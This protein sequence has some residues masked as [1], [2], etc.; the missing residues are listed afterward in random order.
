VNSV[1]HLYSPYMWQLDPR[2]TYDENLILSLES[3]R[4]VLSL[5]LFGVF[6]NYFADFC[7]FIRCSSLL[8][9]LSL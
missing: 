3:V 2:P 6:A 9:D 5:A 1:L 7:S 8:S 4:R